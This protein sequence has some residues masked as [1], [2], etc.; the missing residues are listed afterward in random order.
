[1]IEVVKFDL[2]GLELRIP[3]LTGADLEDHEA[4]LNTVLAP[5]PEQTLRDTFAALYV[6]ILAACHETHPDLTREQLARHVDLRNRK[7]IFE[8]LLGAGSGF[9]AITQEKPAG[10][11]PRP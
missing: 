9:E 3:P 2:R 1:M 4:E 11:A 8:A 6:L 5:K 7:A 10:E